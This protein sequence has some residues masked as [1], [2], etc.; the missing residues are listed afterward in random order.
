VREQLQISKKHRGPCAVSECGDISRSKGYCKRHYQQLLRNGKIIA[1]PYSPERVTDIVCGVPSCKQRN[2]S[3]GLC[4][5]HYR[6]KQYAENPGYYLSHHKRYYA[7]NKSELNRSRVEWFRKKKASNPAF[8]ILHNIS[9]ALR[10]HTRKAF[11]KIG[12][13]EKTLILLGCTPQELVEHLKKTFHS[14][15]VTGEPMTLSNYGL[16]GWHIDHIRPIASFDLT[17]PE[18]AKKACHFSNLQALWWFE[19]LAKGKKFQEA[20]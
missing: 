3:N 12:K 6:Q 5:E 10:N 19:N 11:R 14:H 7:E 9:S 1:A 18:E 20:I 16:R 4:L 15:P 8:K 2:K 13:T 17:N